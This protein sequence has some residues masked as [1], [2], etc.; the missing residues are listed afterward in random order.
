MKKISIGL[1]G[2]L[3]LG[4][5]AQAELVDNS[6]A[7]NSGVRPTKSSLSG[8]EIIEKENPPRYTQARPLKPPKVNLS[9]YEMSRCDCDD[10]GQPLASC[11]EQ[12]LVAEVQMIVDEQGNVQKISLLKSSGVTLADRRFIEGAV[13]AKF[14]PFRI[15]GQAVEG[16]VI[17]PLKFTYKPMM[18]RSCYALQESFK[19]REPKYE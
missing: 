11:Q 6:T 10:Q 12:E 17:A 8:Q 7:T 5:T 2:S 13:R 9:S 4:M 18:Y 14:E 1:A 3:L 15:N 16:N 19:Q